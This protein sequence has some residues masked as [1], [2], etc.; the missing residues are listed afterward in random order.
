MEEENPLYVRVE[1]GKIEGRMEPER[2]VLKSQRADTGPEAP[3][4]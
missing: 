3:G 1:E 4:Q 2:I